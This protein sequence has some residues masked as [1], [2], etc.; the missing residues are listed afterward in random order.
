MMVGGVGELN[1]IVAT[2]KAPE[3][4]RLRWVMKMYSTEFSRSPVIGL[5]AQISVANRALLTLTAM[6]RR[7]QGSDFRKVCRSLDRKTLD[8]SI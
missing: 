1:N 3:H 2:L 5:S 8:S 7:S 6:G 4:V